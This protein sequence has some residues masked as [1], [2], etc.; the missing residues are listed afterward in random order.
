LGGVFH[1]SRHSEQRF[2]PEIGDFREISEGQEATLVEVDLLAGFLP[3][4]YGALR[5][6]YC[7]I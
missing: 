4:N 1:K 5:A 6:R 7:P 3:S 2:S